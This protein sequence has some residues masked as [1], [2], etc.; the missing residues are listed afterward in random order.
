MTTW[1]IDEA[2]HLIKRVYSEEYFDRIAPSLNALAE[3]QIHAR[4]H[5]QETVK[6]LERFKHSY[7]ENEM[8]LMAVHGGDEGAR[9]DFEIL[10]LKVSAHLISTVIAVHS[11]AYL[12]AT[13]FI[14]R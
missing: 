4:F 5:F 9:I 3:R 13:T 6:L 7:L 8:L 1:S 10:M 11:L 14:S 2:W 12:I